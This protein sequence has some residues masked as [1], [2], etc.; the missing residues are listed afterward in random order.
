MKFGFIGAGNMAGAIIKGMTVGTGVCEGKDITAYDINPSALQNLKD[1]CG[2]ATSA[3]LMETAENADVI[4]LAVKP[5]ILPDV[6]P[7]IRVAARCQRKLIVS[8]AVGKTIDYLESYLGKEQPIIRVMPNI[9]AKV[10]AAISGICPNPAA[11]EKDTETAKM[12][13]STV[14][15]VIQ[16][17]ENYFSI[18]GVIAGSSPAF[19]YLYIDALARAAQKAG[20]A[21]SQALEIA[22]QTVLGSAKMILESK[23]HP[24]SLIDQ[25]CSPGGTTIEG[26]ASLEENKFESTITKAFDAVLAKDEIIKNKN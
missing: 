25:V 18:F 10:G 7:Q 17:A 4:V 12:L 9:N 23:E 1:T 8:I 14:G 3:S 11:N 16:I 5:N 2:I 6:L 20:M 22:A 13:F 15:S 24:W 19:A 26:I 21:K